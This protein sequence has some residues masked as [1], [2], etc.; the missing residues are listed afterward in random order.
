MF[1]EST[2]VLISHSRA[3]VRVAALA[4]FSVGNLLK[5][6]LRMEMELATVFHLQKSEK[7]LICF[8][9]LLLLNWNPG[10]PNITLCNMLT[11]L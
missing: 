7:N 4:H 11:D 10:P 9:S 6:L 1:W 2:L 8:V 3:A 5:M